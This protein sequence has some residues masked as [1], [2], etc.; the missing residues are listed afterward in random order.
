MS[1]NV[2]NTIPKAQDRLDVLKK[3]EELEGTGRFDVDV[4]NDPPSKELLPDDIDYLRKGILDKLASKIAFWLAHRFVN[5]MKKSKMLQI[6]EIKGIENLQNLKSGA[7]LTC[8]HFNPFDSFAVQIAYET[9]KLKKRKLFRIIKEGNYT[10]VNG[11]YGFLMRNCNTLPLS[12]NKRTMVK[13][14]K[15]TNEL[16]QKG[17]LVLVYAEQSLWW[18]YRKPKPL[19]DGAFKFAVRNNVPVVP[20]FITMEDSNTI[21]PDGFPVQQYTINIDKP[22]YPDQDKELQDNVDEMKKK[23]EEV[24][25]SIY[26]DFYKIPLEY[27]K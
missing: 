3:I 23:N 9:A 10:S 14:V 6:K 27:L 2:T 17:N 16:L 19:K 7:V 20:M 4:E 24:W 15:A 13:L 12:S 8:N 18:N 1:E 25:K 21:G 26:E 5:K 22:I 11:F